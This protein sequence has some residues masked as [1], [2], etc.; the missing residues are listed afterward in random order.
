M[1]TYFEGKRILLIDHQSSWREA[2]GHALAEHRFLVKTSDAY[3]YSEPKCFVQGGAPDIVIL[4]C[5]SVRR[6]ERRLIQDILAHK[7]RLLILCAGLLREDTRQLFRAGAEDVTDKP[8]SPGS[9]LQIVGRAFAG[10]EASDS[11]RERMLRK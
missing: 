3:T 6:D 2:A 7:R 1:K 8:Y 11:F 10:Q 4:G 9:L 5:A